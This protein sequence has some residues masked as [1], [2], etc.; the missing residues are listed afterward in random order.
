[1]FE[2]S[3]ATQAYDEIIHNI[4]LGGTVVIIGMPVEKVSIDMSSFSIK[5][6]K[7]LIIN[8]F[9]SSFLK[10]EKKNEWISKFSS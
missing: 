10:E 4:C 8:S 9:K 3:G 2:A 1:M 7:T 6:I 5:E